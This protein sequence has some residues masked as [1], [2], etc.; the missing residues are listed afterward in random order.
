MLAYINLPRNGRRNDLH[1]VCLKEEKHI[2]EYQ[3][4]SYLEDFIFHARLLVEYWQEI[5]ETILTEER[6]QDA[7]TLWKEFLGIVVL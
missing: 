2:W 5:I 3:L 6:I 1:K 7:P 4:V